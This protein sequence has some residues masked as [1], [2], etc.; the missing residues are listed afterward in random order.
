MA[1][2]HAYIR[3]PKYGQELSTENKYTINWMGMAGPN[4]I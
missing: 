2:P 1:Q 3:V 4:N